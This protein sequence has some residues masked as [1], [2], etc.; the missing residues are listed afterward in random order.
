VLHTASTNK[1]WQHPVAIGL[2]SGILALGGRSRSRR[3]GDQSRTRLRRQCPPRRTTAPRKGQR[4]PNGWHRSSVV[5]TTTGYDRHHHRPASVAL[6]CSSAAAAGPAGQKKGPPLIARWFEFRCLVNP[7]LLGQSFCRSLASSA[8]FSGAIHGTR[9]INAVPS[10]ARYW[11]F[12]LLHV[13]PVHLVAQCPARFRRQDEL[14]LPATSVRRR[15]KVATSVFATGTLSRAQTTEWIPP[16]RLRADG[17]QRS[18]SR[19]HSGRKWPASIETSPE[20]HA[21]Y[22][23]CGYKVY[24]LFRTQA[25]A[26]KCVSCSVFSAFPPWLFQCSPLPFVTRYPA[27]S[28]RPLP[29][30]ETVR[31]SPS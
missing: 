20:D 8:L 28:I 13:L 2:A 27:I 9:G 23:S 14:H 25:G 6:A 11:G 22:P 17:W 18:L 12:L 10:M 31:T 21:S 5:P 16:R 19:R 15:L 7:S 3:T 1:E 4:S 26:R 29:L 24:V 30:T